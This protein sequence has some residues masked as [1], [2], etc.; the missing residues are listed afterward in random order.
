M[1]VTS[2]V[3]NACVIFWSTI[4]RFFIPILFKN[5]ELWSI[6]QIPEKAI[7]IDEKMICIGSE[8]EVL[9]SMINPL[10]ISIIPHSKLYTVW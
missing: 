9:P 7:S 4:V 2:P 5:A 3:N 1:V 8:I 10:V 6:M